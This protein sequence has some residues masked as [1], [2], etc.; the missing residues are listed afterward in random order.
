M[1][2]KEF[3]FVLTT[4]RVAKERQK[5][6]F[7]YREEAKA[8]DSGWRFFAGTEDQEYVDNPDNIHQYDIST[9]IDI[10][11]SIQPYLSSYPGVAF[12]KVENA[13]RF[14]IVD[15]FDFGAGLEE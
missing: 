13:A 6:G 9:I 4:N 14:D 11:P 15:D 3:G 1:K 7:M 12:E 8:P 10:D 5:V 2:E